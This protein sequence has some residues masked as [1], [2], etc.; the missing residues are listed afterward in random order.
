PDG[1]TLLLAS[2]GPIATNAFLY[3]EMGYDPARWVPIALLATGPYV[4][5]LRKKLRGFDGCGADRACQ[6]QSGQDHVRDAG[7][8][9]GW[10]PGDG[11][12]RNARRHHDGADP[13][14][15]V[16]P[17]PQRSH[18]RTRG[19]DVRYADNLACAASRWQSQDRGGRH[20][21]AR[22]GLAGGSH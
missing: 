4:L 13:L 18:R 10:A 22:A 9:L 15:R 19:H 16:E 14:S 5:V 21:G 12:A 17:R 20:N 6:G 7:R 8:W 1:H 11:P 3:K 2:P